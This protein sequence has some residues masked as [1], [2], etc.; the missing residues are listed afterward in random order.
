MDWLSGAVDYGIIALLLVLSVIVLAVALER[1]LFYRALRIEEFSDEGVLE[2]A[3]ARHLTWISST[4]SNA[5]YLGLLGTVLGIMLAF[6]RMGQSA[7]FDTGAIMIGLALALKA[8]AAGIAVALVAIALY[9]AL[10]ARAKELTL[11]WEIAR[12]AAAGERPEGAP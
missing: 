1:F 4:A 10:L 5:P 2:L 11:R 8:T 7:T 9:N 12:R 3:L 6:Y